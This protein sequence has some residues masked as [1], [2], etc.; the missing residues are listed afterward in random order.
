MSTP[1]RILV[2]YDMN[3]NSA[4]PF[5]QIHKLVKGLVRLGHDTHVFNYAGT[6]QQ[7][8]PFK[9]RSLSERLYKHRVDEMLAAQAAEYEPDIAIITFARA[10]DADSV[11]ALRRAVPNTVFLGFDDDPWPRLQRNR[12]EAA[13][14]LDIVVATNDGEWL[15][16]YRDAGV[17]LCAFVPNACDPGV[18]YRYNVAEEWTSDLLWIGKLRHRADPSDTFRETLVHRL[19][20]NDKAAVY[21]C[22]GKPEIGGVHFLYAASGARIGVSVNAYKPSIRF[23]HS[24]RLVRFL[25]CG[26]MV[27]CR[28]FAGADL[29]F[30]DGEH[31]RYFD[32]IDEFFELADWHLAHE[33]ERRRIA[34]AGMEK[35]HAAFNCQRI[36]GY[37]LDLVETGKYAAPWNT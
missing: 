34:D 36:A 5:C 6:L 33:Q 20:E 30:K 1:K 21:G 26:A 13:R 3:Y 10:L 8:S 18:E 16:D 12:I 28:R 11:C 4:K 15:Q 29:L 31:L 24:D 35:G 14:Q 23:A 27:L 19:A 25:A 37:L 7:L 22:S 32:E 2:I 9:S 17:P